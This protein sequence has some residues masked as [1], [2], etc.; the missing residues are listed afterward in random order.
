MCPRIREDGDLWLNLLMLL[1]R[2]EKAI[3]ESKKMRGLAPYSTHE[4]ASPRIELGL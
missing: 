1:T 2:S 4:T 3:T